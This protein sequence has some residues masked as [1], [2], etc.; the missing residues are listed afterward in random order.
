MISDLPDKSPS[1]STEEA[2]CKTESGPRFIGRRIKG[3]D[4]IQNMPSTSRRKFLVKLSVLSAAAYVAPKVAAAATQSSLSPATIGING[5]GSVT[6]VCGTTNLSFHGSGTYTVSD[7]TL[8]FSQLSIT[9]TFVSGVE[10]GEVTFVNSGSLSGPVVGGT[11]QVT[12]TMAYSDDY[13]NGIPSSTMMSGTISG[14][15]VTAITDC[16]SSGTGDC[17]SGGT[18]EVSIC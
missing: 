11:W 9:G 17:A 10:I 16:E 4:E 14:S 7:G 18:A 13:N 8:T 6:S 2:G 5:L 3:E 12:G 15:T 1:K